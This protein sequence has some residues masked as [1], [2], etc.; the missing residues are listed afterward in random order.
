MILETTSLLKI[1]ALLFPATTLTL[2]LNVLYAPHV[3]IPQ[4]LSMESCS[5]AKATSAFQ[6]VQPQGITCQR[7]GDKKLCVPCCSFNKTKVYSMTFILHGL[8]CFTLTQVRPWRSPWAKNGP[9]R[10]FKW[11][12]NPYF[13]CLLFVLKLNWNKTSLSL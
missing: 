7:K 10:L 12:S 5:L 3:A 1:T 13:T 2:T 8:L 11:H 4:V 6:Q 9:H